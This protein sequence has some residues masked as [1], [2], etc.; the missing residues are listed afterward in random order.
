MR[1]MYRVVL[2]AFAIAIAASALAASAALAAPEWYS[3]PLPTPEW[4]VGGAK[5]TEAT[6]VRWTGT[7]KLADEKVGVECKDTGEGSTGPGATGEDT[8][9][10]MSSC[11]T[12]AGTCPKP[13]M[14]P[15]GMSWHTELSLSGET[16]NDLTTSSSPGYKIV[17][18]GVIKDTCSATTT[19]SAK[20]ENTTAGV[21][22]TFNGENLHCSLTGSKT[23]ALTGAQAVE[24]TGGG[25]LEAVS[26]SGEYAKLTS[27][28][29][30]TSSGTLVIKDAKSSYGME[31][32]VETEGSIETG[33]IGK[34]THYLAR[35]CVVTLGSCKTPATEAINLP[36]K[37]ELYEEAGVI[38]DR[39]VSGGSGTPAWRVTCS[40][41]L[42]DECGLN[43]DPLTQNAGGSVEALFEATDNKTNC[44][45]GGVEAGE[46]RGALLIA[47][48]A[49]VAGIKAQ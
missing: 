38:R 8:K 32:N 20:T 24:T 34:I 1:S 7:V 18:S 42:K 43:T 16:I 9:W 29:A 33:G 3:K 41:V 35:N 4:R 17:C 12:T 10:T 19:I 40:G 13:T 23:G 46:W 45:A 30:V 5:L 31:C 49:G 25:K 21:N 44:S 22:S 26:V 39:I 14:E 11:V 36:W 28:L 6:A 47:H 2:A 27:A 15:M 37:T 48:P